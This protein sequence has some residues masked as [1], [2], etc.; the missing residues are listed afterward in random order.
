MNAYSYRRFSS[1]TQSHGDS[2]RRQIQLAEDYCHKH[3]LE[4]STDSFEDLGVSA[5]H[6]NNSL[7]DA[8]LGQFIAALEEGKIPT[9]CYLLVESLDRLSRA[10]IDEA[11]QQLLAIT[12]Q[13][14]IV[15][16]LFD[17]QTYKKGMGLAE[18]ITA[19]VTMA[20]ANE[21]SETKSK[22]LKAVWHK[23]RT[24]P[25]ALKTNNKPFWLD[26][27]DDKTSFILNESAEL[28]REIYELSIGGMGSHL[29]S[30]H[31]NAKGI[32]SPKG[33][34]W[35]DAVITKVLNT[36][37]V[38]GEYQPNQRVN[39]KS[40]PIGEPIQDF[41]PSVI[42]EQTFYL[43][44]A[45]IKQR[46]KS[47]KRGSTS[48]H[49]NIL[50]D[51]GTC[52]RCSAPLRL[53][54]QSHLYYFRCPESLKGTCDS[55]PINIMFLRDWL[56]EQ[57]LTPAFYKTWSKPKPKLNKLKP[58]EAK[59]QSLGEAYETMLEAFG[60]SSSSSTIK[61]LQKRD[62]E[63]QELDKQIELL[64]QEQAEE[65]NPIKLN[66]DESIKLIETA[67]KLEITAETITARNK[68]RQLMNQFSRF[69]VDMIDKQAI[70]EIDSTSSFIFQSIQNP[71]HYMK[72]K[73]MFVWKML[74]IK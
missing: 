59:R 38:L 67:F 72:S 74:S 27:S 35:G 9:P 44:Q 46:A 52:R 11:L 28:V 65:S 32:P 37:A 53:Q 62:S 24:D 23:R 71:Y 43:S 17:N 61:N 51:V 3:N 7:E 64:K 2:I 10:N 39:R 16:T 4:L 34:T 73:P 14:V 20:R 58:L 42:N 49:L 70:F 63:L 56:K 47:L 55:K 12:N 19:I 8:G 33:K 18:F 69:E 45:Q 1:A 66:M 15:V 60:S 31:L 50:K 6:S 36:K 21:E 29:I 40:V 13:G 41:Y 5:Y 22:R 57:W 25:N 30:K 48:S 68:L 54:K 26:L